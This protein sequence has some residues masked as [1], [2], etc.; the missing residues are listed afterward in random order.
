M[1]KDKFLSLLLAVGVLTTGCSTGKTNTGETN[2][3]ASLKPGTY[4]AVVE[5]F[6]GDITITME[7]DDTKITKIDVSETETPTLG[8]AAIKQLS[9]KIIETQSLSV[10]TVAGATVSST[11][12]LKGMEDG[13]TQAGAN[14]E[15]FK[16][17]ETKVEENKETVELTTDV[18][19]VG[20]GG[21][22]LTAALSSAQGGMKVIL[23]EKMP[24]AGGAS[25]MA[26]G[27]TNATGSKMQE[28]YGIE[29]SPE[30]LFMDLMRNG[31]F[32]NHANTTWLYTNTVGEAFDWL[33]AED[34]AGLKYQNEEPRPSAE[35]SVGRTFSPEG[36]GSGAVTALLEKAEQAGVEVMYETPAKELIEENGVVKGVKAVSKDGTTYQISSKSVILASGGYGANEEL[37]PEDV[38]KLAYAGAV[39][40]TGDGLLMAEK[41]GADTVNLNK[42]NIQPHSIILPDGRGQHTYQGVLTMYGGTG[43]ILVSDK[44]ERFVN[45]KGSGASIKNKMEENEHSY[46]IMD[47]ESFNE[48]TKV[49]IASKNYTEKQLNEWLANNGSS[50]P[51]FA[52]GSNLDELAKVINVPAESLKGTV[53][54][55]N[56]FVKNGKDEDFGRPVSKTMNIDGKVYAVEMNLRY[57]ASLGG[58]RINDNMEVVK[59]DD[60][61]IQG[62]YAA[63]EV[64]GGALGDIYA[65]GALFGWAMTSGYNAGNAVVNANK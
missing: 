43:S 30:I 21:A 63:G 62:L 12:F 31:N 37:L 42:I 51:V 53:D 16:K 18:V 20:A 13:L 2:V 10:D 3:S 60:T 59:S 36:A 7:V 15:E 17:K 29:D 54:K 48:Y 27:G 34:G 22:G 6:S 56:G 4:T 65:P 33:V 19:V 58:L 41:I 45:E 38:K 24:M 52:S 32:S 44:G 57:Y 28:S 61:P 26:G 11:A 23:L 35:H 47:E 1:K 39:S 55:Y 46:L 25:S 8:G 49:C 50:N 64:V 9:E 40:S 14:I 5:G